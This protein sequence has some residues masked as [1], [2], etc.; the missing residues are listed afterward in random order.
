MTSRMK[1]L[2]PTIAVVIVLGMI[3]LLQIVRPLMRDPRVQ[4]IYAEGEDFKDNATAYRKIFD[5]GLVYLHLPE[6]RPE[7]RW[8]EIDFGKKTISSR[9]AVRSLVSVRYVFRDE[10]PGLQIYN[11]G[12]TGEWSWR[13]SDTGAVFSGNGFSCSVRTSDR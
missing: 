2:V 12:R 11:R 1:I 6:A 7:N 13:F 4:V 10:T 8:W 3:G 5:R 9:D